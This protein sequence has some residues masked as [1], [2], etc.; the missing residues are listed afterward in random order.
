V[1][2]AIEWLDWGEAAFALAAA[3]QRPILLRIDTAWC[4]SSRLMAGESDTDP[5]VVVTVNEHFVP[6]RVDADRH[7]ELNER[8]N[9]GGW[10]TNAFLTPRGEL[11][12]GGTYFDLDTFRLLLNR[13]AQ[14]WS[15][16]RT[17]VEDAVASSRRD[18]EQRR[19][20]RPSHD[21]PTVETVASVVDAAMDDFDFRYGGFGRE[22]K[23][24]HPATIEL[25]L[26]E[27]LRTG[28]GRL[29]D[30]ALMS[31]EAM[32]DPGGK[33]PR[34]A[35][36][37]GG[38]FRYAA[39]RDW[40]DPR[41]EKLLEDNAQLLSV[42]LSAFQL[43]GEGQWAAAARSI[44]GY[45]R[46]T[47]TD[48]RRRFFRSSQAA[49]PGAEYYTIAPA[50][51]P[52]DEAPEVDESGYVAGNA[53]TCSA[54]VK[55]GLVLGDDAVLEFAA[56][57]VDGLLRGAR[58]PGDDIL[59]G[60]RI[61]PGHGSGPILLASQ[62]Y[63]ARALVDVYEALGGHNR[64][65]AA[66]A[67][68]D[69]VHARMMDP[70]REA[71]TDTIIEVGAE[72][73]LSQ[74]IHPLAENS[75]AAET[76]LRLATLLDAPAYQTRAH[77]LLRA[78]AGNA[79]D[80][81]IVAAPYALAVLRSLARNPV[82]VQIA[83]NPSTPAARALTRAAHALFVP[84]R[85]VKYVDPERDRTAYRAL[86]ESMANGSAARVGFAG[87]FSQPTSDPDTLVSIIARAATAMFAGI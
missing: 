19:R 32:W 49:V 72:G 46:S 10:P 78:L 53:V 86:S 25:L 3:Q 79:L 29:R 87:S 66:A 82:M 80:Y 48:T 65:E 33:Q 68:L 45:I 71:Y 20:G 42:Y 35:D 81:G 73:Y 56:V 75:V 37:G 31:L 39:H 44:V 83:G 60:H 5:L 58:V 41:Y 40:S 12:T 62:V 55:A 54:F 38:F 6:I 16:R 8:Y 47:L 30:A 7:P 84:V 23:F 1:A 9:L 11:I 36:E 77:A 21:H 64:L 17:E 70:V 2:V 27:H 74:A 67:L 22:P 50:E 15:D 18:A 24:P 51:R 85:A 59:V 57:V 52:T 28:E 4:A 43:T 76:L 63:A 14:N 69:E 13:V 26:A 61:E 34:L